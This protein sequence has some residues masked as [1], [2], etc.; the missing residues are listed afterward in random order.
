M[1]VL[2]N[3]GISERTLNIVSLDLYN[4]WPGCG[5]GIVGGVIAHILLFKVSKST[6]YTRSTSTKFT[7]WTMDQSQC[8]YRIVC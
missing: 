6:V 2:A 1:S 5:L 3:S 4:M 7:M 8:I